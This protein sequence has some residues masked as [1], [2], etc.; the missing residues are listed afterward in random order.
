MRR[1]CQHSVSLGQGLKSVKMLIYCP[2]GISSALKSQT[3]SNLTYSKYI[4]RLKWVDRFWLVKSIVW[5]YSG[6]LKWHSKPVQNSPVCIFGST[7][8]TGSWLML[9][10]IATYHW[11]A[12]IVGGL[13]SQK[14]IFI[15]MKFPLAGILTCNK[16]KKIEFS[17]ILRSAED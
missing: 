12:A 1:L 8:K 9:T 15:L 11:S 14:F 7:V 3:L 16:G 17:W 10:S 2:R 6:W 13:M 4:Y 5:Y